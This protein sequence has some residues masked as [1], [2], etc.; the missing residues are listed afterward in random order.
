M[1]VPG[2]RFSLNLAV[3]HEPSFFVF[4]VTAF[5]SC[6]S[7]AMRLAHGQCVIRGGVHSLKTF[8]KNPVIPIVCRLSPLV[9]NPSHLQTD[10]LTVD[11]WPEGNF[12]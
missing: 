2:F 11:I 12:H 9:S 10:I 3:L 8:L 1:P 7:H 4:N 6:N 5:L